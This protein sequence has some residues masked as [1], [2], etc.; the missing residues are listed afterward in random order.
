[1]T[2]GASPLLTA[3][4][5]FVAQDLEDEASHVLAVKNFSEGSVAEAGHVFNQSEII[6][7][8]LQTKDIFSWVAERSKEE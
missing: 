4:D 2:P 7:I 5:E 1:M 6:F 8:L 3:V